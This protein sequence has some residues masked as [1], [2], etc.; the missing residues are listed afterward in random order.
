MEKLKTMGL[1]LSEA[2]EAAKLMGG[3]AENAVLWHLEST[4]FMLLHFNFTI[5]VYVCCCSSMLLV[6]PVGV[7]APYPE[8]CSFFGALAECGL[9]PHHVFTSL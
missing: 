5:I 4:S 9:G 8:C 6:V 2:Q 7:V 1:S 3:D